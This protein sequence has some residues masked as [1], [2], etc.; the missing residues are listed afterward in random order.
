MTEITHDLEGIYYTTGNLGLDITHYKNV[1]LIK[2]NAVITSAF[3]KKNDKFPKRL[4]IL[5]NIKIDFGN[6]FHEKASYIDRKQIEDLLN[7]FDAKEP[8]ELKNKEVFAY[9]NNAF[10]VGI[11]K[12]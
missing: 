2:E 1:G 9:S 12:R 8:G 10:F 7:E 11:S 3:Y 4:E 6:I 5:F